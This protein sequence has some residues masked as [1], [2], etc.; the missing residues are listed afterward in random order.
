[1]EIIA[2][3]QGIS[4]VLQQAKS[5]LPWSDLHSRLIRIPGLFTL[6]EERALSVAVCLV[7][8]D[9]ITRGNDGSWALPRAK[10]RS[11]KEMV[12]EALR[13]LGQPAHFTEITKMYMSLFPD[14]PRK[15]N[16]IHAI[17]AQYEDTLFV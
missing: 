10:K 8:T 1:M 3:Q 9:Q 4:A 2:I 14:A 16:N 7:E 12:N 15:V 13:R 11:R 6:Q 17:L 5:P